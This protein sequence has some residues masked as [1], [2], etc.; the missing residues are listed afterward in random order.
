[1]LRKI[2]FAANLKHTSFCLSTDVKDTKNDLIHP[3]PCPLMFALSMCI[4]WSL[5]LTTILVLK[6]QFKQKICRHRTCRKYLTR[7]RS[8]VYVLTLFWSKYTHSYSRWFIFNIA[9]CFTIGMKWS[10]FTK[11]VRILTPKSFLRSTPVA[12]ASKLLWSIFVH[13]FL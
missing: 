7:F 4:L 2:L 13:I 6:L 1:M 3:I 11:R 9:N 10:S 5:R 8:G 12:N